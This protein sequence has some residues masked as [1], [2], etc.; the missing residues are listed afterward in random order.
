MTAYLAWGYS[1]PLAAVPVGKM[2]QRQGRQPQEHRP[3]ER[4]LLECQLLECQSL[5]QLLNSAV[6]Q[7]RAWERLCV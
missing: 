7:D 5:V 3:L 1:R 2:G 6:F 4:Q